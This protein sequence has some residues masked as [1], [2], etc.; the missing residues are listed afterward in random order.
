MARNT[1]ASRLP[2]GESH[3]QEGADREDEDDEEDRDS[4]AIAGRAFVREG[5]GRRAKNKSGT[6]A[7]SHS[8]AVG[9]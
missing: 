4:R 2:R 3:L 1:S 7:A 6:A 8:R 9:R 5:G